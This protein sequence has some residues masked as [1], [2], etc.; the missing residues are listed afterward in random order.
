MGSASR[1]ALAKARTSLQGGLSETSGSELLGA[2]DQIAQSSALAAVLGDASATIESKTQLLERLFG[3]LSAGARG[4]LI[5]AVSEVWSNTD[6]FIAGIEELGLRAEALA[7]AELPEELLAIADLVDRSHELQLSL[8]SK[9]I[10]A[11]GKV[12]LVQRLLAGKASVSATSIV[13]HLVTNPRGRRLD[14]ALRDA[15]RI[16]ADQEGFELATVTVASPLSADQHN[17]LTRL[18]EQSAG[19][20]V[21]IT[22]V[23]DAEILGG[24]RIQL[25]DDMI[26]GSV[27]ARLDD[28]RQQLAA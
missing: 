24:V 6:E 10:D 26:D 16:A 5:S 20:P 3:S 18:L 23:I 4:V 1:E 8:G 9:L 27:S 7:H 11:K 2:S 22:T 17:R 25:A 15:A 21:K 19:R 12:R 14:A 13:S 28:L